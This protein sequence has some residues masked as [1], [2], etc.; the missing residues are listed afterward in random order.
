MH[1]SIASTIAADSKTRHLRCMARKVQGKSRKVKADARPAGLTRPLESLLFLLPLLLIYQVALI[2]GGYDP[3]TAAQNQ[4]IAFQLLQ[5]FFRLFGHSGQWMPL[6]AVV[7]ILLAAHIASRTGWKVR[8]QAVLWLYPES[9]GWAAPILCVAKL[10]GL[11]ATV[12]SGYGSAIILSI[13]AGIYEELVFRLMLICLIVMLGSDLFAWPEKKVLIAA[14]VVS[15]LIFAGHHYVPIGNHPFNPLTFVFRL[16]AGLYLGWLFVV[17]GYGV[18]AGAH[19][20]YNFM[21]VTWAA[22]FKA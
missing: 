2:W 10:L 16:A 4:V 8:P 7:A 22:L 3:E 6:L 5:T 1:K 9:V 12:A 21:M 14:V 20:A 13:G 19:V 18:A 11:S 17:R 15:S